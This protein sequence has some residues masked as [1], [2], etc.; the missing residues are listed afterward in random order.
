MKAFI[1]TLLCFPLLALASVPEELKDLNVKL[2]KDISYVKTTDGN[3]N[4]FIKRIQDPAY[5]L[6]DDF[7]K[8]SRPCPPFC[9]QPT[10]VLK[11]VKNI[12][13]LELLDFIRTDVK[14]NTGILIDA[15]LENWYMVETIPSAINLPF[16]ILQK[17]DKALIKDIFTLFGMTVK[18]D[19]TW[20]FSKAKKLAI[21]CNG[22]WCKQSKNFV[23][24]LVKHNYPKELLYYYRSGFQGWKLLGL[25]TVIH[26]GSIK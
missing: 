24:A 19:G 1:Y 8:T 7:T 10:K 15:R 11:G 13:E 12:A 9:I 4:I 18:P 2:T 3:T 16:P 25:T 20:D 22:V 6:T 17:A 23:D 21:F 14:N 26:E 5:K